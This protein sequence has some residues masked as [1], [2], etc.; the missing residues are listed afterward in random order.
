MDMTTNIER[1]HNNNVTKY[2]G[3]PDHII[4]IMPEWKVALYN[5]IVASFGSWAPNNNK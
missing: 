1:A 5:F 3:L 2:S 4:E